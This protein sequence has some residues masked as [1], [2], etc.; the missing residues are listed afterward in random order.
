MTD[1]FFDNLLLFVLSLF[2][3]GVIFIFGV[4]VYA[5]VTHQ[6]P[7]DKMYDKCIEDGRKDYECYGLIYRSSR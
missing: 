7:S 3:L 6:L 4:F 5:A 1:S 2:V